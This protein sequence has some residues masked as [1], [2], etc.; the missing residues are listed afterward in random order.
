MSKENF[1]YIVKISN[2]STTY[3]EDINWS[4]PVYI[5]KQKRESREKKLKRIYKDEL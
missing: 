2:T 1:K 4:N 3:I 5:A